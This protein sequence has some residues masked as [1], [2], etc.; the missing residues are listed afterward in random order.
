MDVMSGIANSPTIPRMSEAI[1]APLV[2][3][4]AAAAVGCGIRTSARLHG[5]QQHQEPEEGDSE[6]DPAE[7]DTRL[8]KPLAAE[9]GIARDV[10]LRAPADHDRDDGRDDRDDQNDHAPAIPSTSA[11]IALPLVRGRGVG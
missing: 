11:A 2:R 3:G 10:A 4:R 5:C 7:N 1:A 6:A 8:C 9:R